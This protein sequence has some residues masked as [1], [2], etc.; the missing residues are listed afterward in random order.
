MTTKSH[1]TKLLALGRWEWVCPRCNSS[2]FASRRPS[3]DDMQRYCI[4]C[5]QDTGRLTQRICPASEALGARPGP[6]V[7]R[8]P[9]PQIVAGID[10]SKELER[11]WDMCP[12]LGDPFESWRASA[13]PGSIS[14]YR[15][16]SIPQVRVSR[17][18]EKP[19]RPGFYVSSAHRPGHRIVISDYPGITPEDT[20]ATLAYLMIEAAGFEDQE[21]HFWDALDVLMLKAY[22]VRPATSIHDHDKYTEPLRT[23]L[24]GQ[25]SP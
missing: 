7:K 23:H 13:P 4:R 12:D 3:L 11:L 21:H 22:G 14:P 2:T 25:R 9:K 24:A 8:I 1:K 10:L 15:N 6:T 16:S 20:L 17:C 19:E 5:S 18:S